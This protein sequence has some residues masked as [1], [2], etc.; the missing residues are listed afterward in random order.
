MV[1]LILLIVNFFPFFVF[2]SQLDCYNPVD[3]KF[4][5]KLLV[6]KDCHS[7]DDGGPMDYAEV[8]VWFLKKLC[9]NSDDNGAVVNLF[10]FFKSW[11]TAEDMSC[12]LV[13]IFLNHG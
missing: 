7:D 1:F 4:F 2:H 5:G 13:Y 3:M 8:S 10:L 12:G 9:T 11:I 6:N